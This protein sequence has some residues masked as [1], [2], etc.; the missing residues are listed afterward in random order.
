[1]EGNLSPITIIPHPDKI[2]LPSADWRIKAN[3]DDPDIFFA[4]ETDYVLGGVAI[5]RVAKVNRISGEME[6]K[7]FSRT[8]PSPPAP[9]KCSSV[10]DLEKILREFDAA[11]LCMGI[12]DAAGQKFARDGGLIESG[13]FEIDAWRSNGYLKK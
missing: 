11:H 5:I 10:S 2:V 6:L 3:P 8:C 13:T 4:F 12:R 9:N 1:M 7:V